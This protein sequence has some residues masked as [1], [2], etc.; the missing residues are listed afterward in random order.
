MPIDGVRPNTA[1]SGKAGIVAGQN[2]MPA[3]VVEARVAA[4]LD[5]GLVRFSTAFGQL[6]LAVDQALSVGDRARI[7]IE[8]TGAKL[9][10]TLIGITG[11]ADGAGARPGTVVA[12][13]ATALPA[14]IPPGS[15]VQPS[16]RAPDEPAQAA[17]AMARAA[18]A[19]QAPAS[20]LVAKLVAVIAGAAGGLP[21]AV[22]AA[23]QDVLG[24][25][26][27][28]EA[29]PDAAALQEAVRRSGIFHEALAARDG[30]APADL[31]QALT[32]LKVAL[33]AWT[34][35][36]RAGAPAAPPAQPVAPGAAGE[37][38]AT[39]PVPPSDPMPAPAQAAVARPVAV[40]PPVL[41]PAA[42]A[43]AMAQAAAP[44]RPPVPAPGAVAAGGM[45][46]EA[47]ALP[48]AL[49]RQLVARAFG[50]PDA[51]ALRSAD[52]TPADRAAAPPRADLPPRAVAPEQAPP[53]FAERPPQ[54]L[55]EALLSATEGAL[56]RL[57]LAQYASLPREAPI[58]QAAQQPA[59]QQAQPQAWVMDLPML[60]GRE[61]TLAQMRITRDGR[62]PT[63]EA[64][65][66]AWSIDVA[67]DT[68]ETGP[69]HARVRLGA[70]RLGV[71]LWAERTDTAD[72]L[73][74]DMPALRRTLDDAAF[75]VD[76]VA[77]LTGAPSAPP[78]GGTTAGYL[79]DTRS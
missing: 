68:S 62:G 10:L 8:N 76:D 32:A 75:S 72:R 61:A 59:S 54:E 38:P 15:G 48:P 12:Q 53:G 55:R 35:L 30:Q 47:L 29:P 33:A 58:Q 18:A 7:M 63:A 27:R 3:E 20:A 50:S 70:G 40:P 79:L 16:P 64:E 43:A 2:A 4:I 46:P 28:A 24:S 41:P 14:A 11:Q 66:P 65:G 1:A 9:T 36:E 74:Q 71:T 31:K 44:G 69:I 13:P 25:P 45:S 22:R 19:T 73:R 67:V 49:L 39:R 21:P 57:K 5:N 52:L 56:D 78:K 6:D 77:I 37:A 34:P 17:Q 60:A 51:A 26:L 42:V 23:A